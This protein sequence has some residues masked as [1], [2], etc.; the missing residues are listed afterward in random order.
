MSNSISRSSLTDTS[1]NLLP[2]TPSKLVPCFEGLREIH[3]RGVTINDFRKIP[4][5][6]LIKKL[7]LNISVCVYLHR[8][9]WVEE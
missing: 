5:L 4:W 9:Y 7:I 2:A 1:Q 6:K 8:F 3:V